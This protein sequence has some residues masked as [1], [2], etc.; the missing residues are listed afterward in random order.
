MCLQSTKTTSFLIF[1][2]QSQAMIIY[3]YIYI[4]VTFYPQLNLLQVLFL[5][6]KPRN[7]QFMLYLIIV[8]KQMSNDAVK[9]KAL[10][11][12]FK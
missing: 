11:D 6:V 8:W 9:D 3:I 4:Y 2:L 10:S 5:S 7:K 1:I 12:S